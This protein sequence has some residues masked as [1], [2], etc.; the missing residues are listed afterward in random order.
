MT[1]DPLSFQ[2]D[3]PLFL[4]ASGRIGTGFQRLARMGHWP[5]PPPLWQTRPGSDRQSEN[6]LIWDMLAA[7][8]PDFGNFQGIIALAGVVNGDLGLNTDLALAAIDL[9]RTTGRGPVL[10]TSTAAVYGRLTYPA[11]EET[12]CYPI[13]DYGKAKLAME[14]A[15]AARRR[16][17]GS[18]APAVCILRIGNVAGADA[19]LAAAARG[20]VLLDHFGE[21]LGPERSYIGMLDLARTMVGLIALS[22]RS[23]PLPPILNI[24]ATRPAQ[25][26]VLLQAAGPT[27]AWQPAPPEAMRRIVLD[28]SKLDAL[29]APHPKSDD[30]AELIRQARLVG[31]AP[32]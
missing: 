32:A 13:S 5:G 17:L 6:L 10:L 21:N 23:I 7:A 29:V 12:A 31:W 3:P 30:P 20:P 22:S 9:A 26:S 28:T 16:E 25:M 8:P 11:T 18:A 1:H 15:V 24:A 2:G 27:W 19:L 14:Q 4:G